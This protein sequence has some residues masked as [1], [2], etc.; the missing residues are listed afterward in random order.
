MGDFQFKQFQIRDDHS[1]MKVGTDSVLL[2]AWVNIQH[3]NS[4]LDIGCGSGLISQIM[5]QRIPHAQVVGVEIDP[6][7]VEDAKFNIN[8]SPWSNRLKVITEDILKYSPPH[9]FDLIIS[10]PPFFKDSLKPDNQGRAGARHDLSLD[11][12]DLLFVASNLLSSKGVFTL[13]FPY[14]REEELFN[15]ASKFA[16]YPHR[17][18]RSRNKPSAVIKRTFVE[19]YKDKSQNL[20]IE[21]LNIRDVNNIYS[22]EYQIITSDYYLKF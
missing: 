10:N 8:R 4:V 17:I 1:S 6:S 21:N 11:L 20:R 19:F 3:V 13:V 15:M 16:L 7:S 22:K 12:K 2:G 14:D 18:L 5:A 9:L